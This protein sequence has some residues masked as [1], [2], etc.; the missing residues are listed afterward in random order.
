[1][2]SGK[3][4]SF[5]KRESDEETLL[6]ELLSDVTKQ[7]GQQIEGTALC[8]RSD[9]VQLFRQDQMGDHILYGCHGC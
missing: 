8:E 5:H 2:K 7:S 9:Q 6:R 4:K 1:M 3:Q